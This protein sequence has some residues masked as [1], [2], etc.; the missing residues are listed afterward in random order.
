MKDK[1]WA[2]AEILIVY[3]IMRLVMLPIRATGLIDA[4]IRL[5]GWTYIGGLIQM[6]VPLVVIWLTRRRW[7]DYGLT[8]AGWPIDLDVGIK[9]YLV[10]IIPI[11]LGLGGTAMLKLDYRALPGGLVV[12]LAEMLGIAVMLWVLRRQREDKALASARSNLIVSGLLLLLPILVALAMRR[13]TL[14]IVSTVVW[15]FVFSGFGEEIFLRGYVQSRL[16]QAFGRPWMWFG[17]PCGPGL[18]IASLLFGLLHAFNTYDPAAG[19]Y[20]LAWGWA[21]FATCGGLFLDRKSVV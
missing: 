20:T 19:E 13:L 5:L 15:Q 17:V 11:V 2:C 1:F 9:A 7:A 12:A 18:I 10:R 6:A 8:L 4:E 14:L 16:N 21:L 3:A